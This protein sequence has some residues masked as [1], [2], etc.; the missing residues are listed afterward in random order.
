MVS[1]TC[2]RMQNN[3]RIAAKIHDGEGKSRN[4]LHIWISVENKKGLSPSLKNCLISRGSVFLKEHTWPKA[5]QTQHIC[6]ILSDVS[7][8]M[9][10]GIDVIYIV[11]RKIN[12][13]LSDGLSQKNRGGGGQ[14]SNTQVVKRSG[15]AGEN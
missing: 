14:S 4:F 5:L 15:I 12:T 1:E 11:S 3:F 9:T 7:A 8:V 6:I 10:Y 2:K 13:K